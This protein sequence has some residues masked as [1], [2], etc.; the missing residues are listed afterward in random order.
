MFLFGYLS[1][2]KTIKYTAQ[3]YSEVQEDSDPLF[4]AHVIISFA[5]VLLSYK[6]YKPL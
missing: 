1:I 2:Q 6:F 5:V 3:K 4:T